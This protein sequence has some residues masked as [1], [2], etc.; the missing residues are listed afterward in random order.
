[1]KNAL[2][3]SAVSLGAV[4]AV[5]AGTAVTASAATGSMPIST[6]SA[7]HITP[8]WCGGPSGRSCN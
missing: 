6:G 5:M 1:M 2:K 4:M 8:L 7:S 3:M